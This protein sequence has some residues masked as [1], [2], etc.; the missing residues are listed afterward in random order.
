MRLEGFD[1]TFDQ[2]LD[3]LTNQRAKN[4]IL[5]PALVMVKITRMGG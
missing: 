1:F 2:S 5:H 3:Q 4:L